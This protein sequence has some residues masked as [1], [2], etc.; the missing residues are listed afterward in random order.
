VTDDEIYEAA[1]QT[2]LRETKLTYWRRLRYWLEWAYADAFQGVA[3]DANVLA[4]QR[5]AKLLDDRFYLAERAVLN[6]AK[7][8]GLL[9]TTEKVKI[10]SWSYTLVRAGGCA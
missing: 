3:N 2:L 8:S 7:E 1:I 5:S 9:T 4:D 10:N 6:A